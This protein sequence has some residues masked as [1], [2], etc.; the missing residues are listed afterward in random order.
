MTEAHRSN[1]DA[2]EEI[3]LACVVGMLRRSGPLGLED[4]RDEPEL[5]DWP[6]QRLEQAV[7]TAWSRNL[8]FVDQRDLLVAL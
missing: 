4:L 8:I 7:V 1:P 5:A 2:R 3:D 6:V